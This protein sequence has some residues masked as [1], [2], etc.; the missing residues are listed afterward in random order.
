[1]RSE[2]DEK[3]ELVEWSASC[4]SACGRG[5]QGSGS[6]SSDPCKPG[7]QGAFVQHTFA[8]CGFIFSSSLVK[9]LG[10]QPHA[11]NRT[12]WKSILLEI[13]WNVL[14]KTLRFG[15][16]LS[17]PRHSRPLPLPWSH[18]VSP[19]WGRVGFDNSVQTDAETE[20]Q[21]GSKNQSGN[22]NSGFS[23]P[24]CICLRFIAR[25][26]KSGPISNRRPT[27][28][29][30]RKPRIPRPV[31]ISLAFS[32]TDLFPRRMHH[33]CVLGRQRAWVWV[34]RREEGLK[35]FCASLPLSVKWG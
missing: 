28:D 21:K 17:S 11:T 5:S 3:P 31:T 9:F 13:S 8:F 27:W 10:L 35:S 30:Q 12:A 25:R 20:A 22:W 2:R 4:V 6:L 14:L 33:W 32:I 29:A 34:L 7:L 1:M 26:S 16:H 19:Q 15:W 18:L 23:P 24:S